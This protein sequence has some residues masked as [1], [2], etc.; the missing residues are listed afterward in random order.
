MK[1]LRMFFDWMTFWW[2]WIDPVQ[3][4]SWRIALSIASSS[5]FLLIHRQLLFIKDVN[6]SNLSMI[7]IGASIIFVFSILFEQ[8]VSSKRE[9]QKINRVLEEKNKQ[10]HE[11]ALRDSLTGLYNNR[12]FMIDTIKMIAARAKR[13]EGFLYLLFADIDDLGTINNLYDHITGD[14]AIIASAETFRTSL[15]EEDFVFRYGGD[16]FLA[17][18][19]VGKMP[20]HEAETAVTLTLQRITQNTEN[21]RIYG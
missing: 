1:P 3:K 2:M 16:E 7:V 17:I 19:Y 13:K 20:E 14:Y 4:V 21:I 10:L 15:R 8:A 18:F 5:F 9:L 11:M 12:D 6:V